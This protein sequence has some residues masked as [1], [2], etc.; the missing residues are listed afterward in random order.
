MSQGYTLIWDLD[1]TLFDSYK[2]IIPSMKQTLEEYGIA[3]E[4]EEILHHAILSSLGDLMKKIE[5]AYGISA[6]DLNRRSMELRDSRMHEITAA[7]YAPEILA[8][9]KEKGVANHIFTHRG[10]S[11]LPILQHLGI[12]RYFDEIITA[13]DGFPRKPEPD[14]IFYLM[15]RY[16]LDSA[17]TYYVGDRQIDMECARRAGIGC[18]LYLPSY[19][20]GKASG[21]EDYV[22]SDFR[23]L[24]DIIKG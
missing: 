7:P 23:E 5:D 12:D 20:V 22:I 2:V 9:L 14:A 3:M 8:Y 11:T 17:R 1:G 18:I 21:I 13:V 19:S 6:E 16:E 10:Q 15:K 24:K 4:E